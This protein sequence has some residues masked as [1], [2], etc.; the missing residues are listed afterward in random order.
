MKEFDYIG[1]LI[2][3]WYN[4]KYLKIFKLMMIDFIYFILLY[5]FN[6]YW[7]FILKVIYFYFEYKILN[8][9]FLVLKNVIFKVFYFC[10]FFLI[11]WIVDSI[12]RF[13]NIYLSFVIR[14]VFFGEICI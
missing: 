5:F 13:I 3:V 10:N 11:F 14:I 7:N 6:V 1:W 4:C 12:D 2:V 9:L 8:V